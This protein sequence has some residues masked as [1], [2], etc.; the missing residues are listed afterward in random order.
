M[1]ID[2]T[3]DFDALLLAAQAERKRYDDFVDER[4]RFY[5]VK[6]M[7][8]PENIRLELDKSRNEWIGW[9]R[10]NITDRGLELY[11]DQLGRPTAITAVL[12]GKKI[13]M[14]EKKMKMKVLSAF[15]WAAEAAL[16]MAEWLTTLAAVMLVVGVL[17]AGYF[18][19]SVTPSEVPVGL[20]ISL[21]SVGP[22]L[23]VVSA[24]LIGLHLLM[25]WCSE[26]MIE[27]MAKEALKS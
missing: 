23:L 13:L 14:K 17:A 24:V 11:N 21:V 4:R 2:P 22:G 16:T 6:T 7:S 20:C 25:E 1:N 8:Y 26:K 10:K 18:F 5:N 27:I 3:I 12:A 15:E 9:V 19:G